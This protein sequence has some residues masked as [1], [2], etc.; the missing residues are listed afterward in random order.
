[1]SYHG[2]IWS[3]SLGSSTQYKVVLNGLDP[4]RVFFAH[5]L[6]GGQMVPPSL[7]P[8]EKMVGSNP[9][10]AIVWYPITCRGKP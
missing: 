7:S 8:V 6:F 5:F 4:A 10:A 1:M 3:P 9:M 2:M